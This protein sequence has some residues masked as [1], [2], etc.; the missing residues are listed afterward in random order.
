MFAAVSK[1]DGTRVS[2]SAVVISLNR[3][4]CQQRVMK[5]LISAV[6]LTTVLGTGCQKLPNA[7]RVQA[8]V[9]AVLS[10]HRFAT[11]VFAISGDAIISAVASRSRSD[12]EVER[13]S[14]DVPQ[15][16]N[17]SVKITRY[18]Y[19]GSDWAIV[20]KLFDHGRC[21]Q[22]AAEIERHLEKRLKTP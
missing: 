4:H 10:E 3:P 21:Q 18:Q 7:A 22:E 16:G 13:V 8:T 14:I 1:S 19:I 2:S 12:S 11:P 15:D 9:K 5:N 17:A 20:G 6:L